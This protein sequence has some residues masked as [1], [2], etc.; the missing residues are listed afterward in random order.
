MNALLLKNCQNYAVLCLSYVTGF[1]IRKFGQLAS[2]NFGYP[3]KAHTAAVL[4][5]FS[6]LSVTAVTAPLKQGFR[7]FPTIALSRGQLQA[8]RHFLTKYA[9][10]F[11]CTCATRRIARRCVNADFPRNCLLIDIARRSRGF[12]IRVTPGAPVYGEYVVRANCGM[13]YKQCHCYSRGDDVCK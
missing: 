12:T 4:A 6:R 3:Y 9:T 13:K 7:E 10:E 1:A 5:I 2:P 8:A 11:V